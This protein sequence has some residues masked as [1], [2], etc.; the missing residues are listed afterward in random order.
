MTTDDMIQLLLHIVGWDA[1]GLTCKEGVEMRV[2]RFLDFVERWMNAYP[3][4]LTKSHKSLLQSVVNSLP[5]HPSL[6]TIH[7]G[8]VELLQE[9]ATSQEVVQDSSGSGK[10][11]LKL[12]GMMKEKK[13]KR[14]DFDEKAFHLLGYTPTQ[15]AQQLT[16]LD[17]EMFQAI[18]PNEFFKTAWSK[19]DKEKKA[20]NIVRMISRFNNLSYWF[21]QQIVTCENSDERAALLRLLIH[22][23]REFESLGNYQG[24]MTINAALNNSS[25]SR[26]KLTWAVISVE[27]KEIFESLQ[28]KFH[29]AGNFKNYRATLANSDPP[30][31][32]FL[33]LFLTDLTF[34]D[35]NPDLIN[36]TLSIDKNG[37]ETVFQESSDFDSFSDGEFIT[38]NKKGW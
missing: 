14:G 4:S 32:P 15:L 25:I 1:E 11:A 23:S 3:F 20:P 17:A 21:Q 9:S 30:L 27:D 36:V 13:G 5:V 7:N 34:I 28:A 35:E 10:K 19:D 31:I 38:F 2:A 18:N 33:G 24:M 37:S 12:M 16:I 29:P 6:Q 26:L 8:V 22:M